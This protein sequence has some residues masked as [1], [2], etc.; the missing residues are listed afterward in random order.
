MEMKQFKSIILIILLLISCTQKRTDNPPATDEGFIAHPIPR[1]MPHPDFETTEL[2]AQPIEDIE[3]IQAFPE[4]LKLLYE[5]LNH[6]NAHSKQH[7][8]DLLTS[9]DIAIASLNQTYLMILDKSENMLWQYNLKTN[10][11]NEI[12]SQG[13][14][15]G[16]LIFSKD[17]TVYNNKVLV[18]MQGYKIS[19]FNCSKGICE[20]EK[21]LKNELNNYSVTAAK[22]YFYVL[23]IPPFGRD[24]DPDP[25]N[26]DQYT[27]HK[28]THNGKLETSFSPVYR[29]RAPL[30][31]DRMV[32]KGDI[33]YFP[34][35]TIVS[36]TFSFFQNIYLYNDEGE[37]KGKFEVSEFQQP[38]YA[39]KHN[40]G[41]FSGKLKYNDNSSILHTTKI[42]EKWL[43]LR[44][45]E[46]RD[47]EFI[48]REEGFKGD[49]WYSYYAFD[50]DKTDLYKIGR[51]KEAHQPLTGSQTVFPT[52][53][54]LVINKDSTISWLSI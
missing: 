11:P 4:S 1:K 14:G 46:R 24:Q 9:G 48:S 12:S 33:N 53:Y 43:V 23:G 49:E 8:L 7:D 5:F 3:A 34:D 27:I 35:Q 20:Y 22:Q 38:Y 15:P 16:D 25:A 47:L 39:Y 18:S 51:D 13:R 10:E 32:A 41:N 52:D 37:L 31:R 30:V 2:R 50:I 29:H 28:F 36:A 19:V 21:T 44:V 42:G 6:E 45:R 40:R 26:T 54:G 17:V